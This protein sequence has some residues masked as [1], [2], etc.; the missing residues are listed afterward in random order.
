MNCW[1]TTLLDNGSDRGWRAARLGCGRCSSRLQ[2]HLWLVLGHVL[3]VH[4]H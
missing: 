1:S 4:V 3:T 2:Q